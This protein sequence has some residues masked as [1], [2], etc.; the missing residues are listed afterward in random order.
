M[1]S[2]AQVSEAR[3]GTAVE[4]AEHQRADAERVARADQLLV[5]EPDEGVG[6]FEHLQAFDEA[7]DEAVAMR[8]RHQMQ[9]HLGVRGRL[10]HGAFAH[11]LATQ[12][13]P[14]GEVAVMADG[15]AAGIELGKQRLHVAQNGPAGGRIAHVADGGI[16]GQAI[17]HLA[18]RKR[19]ADQAQAALGMKT[20]A[21]EGD[22]AGG[23]L[24]AVLQR[25]QAERGDGRG[26]GVA[27]NTEYAAFFAQ[28]VGIKI[29]EGGFCHAHRPSTI[30]CTG[31]VGRRDR[32]LH[33][34]PAPASWLA[35]IALIAL[36]PLI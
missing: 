13:E 12:R 25:V 36:V 30:S 27:E 6:A 23:F 5:G 3:I 16:A 19:V 22:D 7:V 34:V 21:V 4:L 2:S 1:M 28:P 35:I 32:V 26:V 8:A 29:E 31:P 10:H 14:V 9:D 17:D 15:K 20:R 18:A 24:A 11:Q 33:A